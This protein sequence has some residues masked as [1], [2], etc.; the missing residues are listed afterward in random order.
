MTLAALAC[1]LG[2]CALP[3]DKPR[4]GL[5]RIDHIVVVYAENRSFDNL[6]GMFPG[7]NGIANATSAQY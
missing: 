5:A 4:S 6:Y 2:A 3:R 1:A 7:A